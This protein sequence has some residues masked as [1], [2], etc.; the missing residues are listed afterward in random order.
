MAAWAWSISS[1]AAVL[2]RI[3]GL[4]EPQG[5]AYVL[6]TDTVYVASGGDGSLRR[7]AG[8][9]L[10]PLGATILGEDADNV[11][12]D[13]RAG[14]VIVGYGDGALALIDAASD[15]KTGD[16][17][18][19]GHP[20]AFQL[21][22]SGSRVFVNVPQTRQVVVVDR[23]AGRQL[24]VWNIEGQANFPMALD[25][26]GPP[27]DRQPNPTR[28]AG[29]RHRIRPSAW[30]VSRPVKMPM[31]CSGTRSATTST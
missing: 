1:T 18:L 23:D 12:E 29:V 6:A 31:T 2:Q 26:A 24:T 19:P 17:A 7:F 21:E 4:K 5:V 14:R 9:D 11:R 13:R 3:D 8:A 30:R 22:A 16:I 27:P 15:A 10:A 20:E 28:A 25:E